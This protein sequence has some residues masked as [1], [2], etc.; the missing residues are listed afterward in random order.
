MP[1]QWTSLTIDA[2][3]VDAWA[4]HYPPH[5]TGLRT[6]HL[7]GLDIDILDPDLAHEIHRRA[8]DRF[9]AT[10]MRVGRWP[11]R[12]LPYRTLTPFRKIKVPGIE[13]LGA[14]QQFVAFGIHPVTGQPYSWPLGDTPLDVPLDALPVVDEDGLRA[15]LG[16]IG[17]ILPQEASG[18]RARR[19]PGVRSPS[20]GPVRDT[21]GRVLDGRDGWLSAIAFHAVHDAAERGAPR[22]AEALTAEVWARFAATADLDR[23][24]QGTGR[25]FALADARAKVADKLR[26]LHD[27]RLPGRSSDVPVP[28]DAPATLPVPEARAALDAGLAEACGEIEAWQATRSAP[29]PRIGFRASVGLGKSGLSRRHVMALRR[30]LAQQGLP[31]RILVFVPSHALA[32]EAAAAWRQAGAEVAVLRGY[33]ARD[34][35]TGQP[36]CRETGAVQTAIDA[37]LEVQKAVCDDGEG[38]RCRH[39][40]TCA[41]QRNRREVAAADIVVASHA[42]LFSGFAVEAS[43]IGVLLID[44]GFHGQV[45]EIT[46][47][48][49]VEGLAGMALAGLGRQAL[50]HRAAAATADLAALRQKAVRAL[51]ANGP[52]S[53]RKSALLAEGLTGEACGAALRLEAR[54]RELLH[55]HPGM[56]AADQQAAAGIVARNVAVDRLTAL[57]K[58]LRDL[59]SGLPESDGRVRI[60]D[61]DPVTGL[62]GIAVIGCREFHPNF[63]SLPVLHL[64]ATLRPE[65]AGAL[66]PGLEVREIEAA[67]PHM[68]L[69]LVAGRFGKT[70][71]CQDAR[72]SADENARRARKRADCVDYVRWHA[73]RVAPGRTL[74]VTYKD[75]EAAFE[76]IPGVEV[77]HFNAIAGLDAWRDV[78]LLIVIGRV[79][80]RDS[81]L[82]A[83]VA[84]LFGHAIEGGYS[85]ATKGIRMRDGSARAVRV[86]RHADDK[87]EI[88]RAAICDDEMIQAIGRGRGVNR[89]A[90][91]PLEVHVLADVALPLVHDRVTS[92]ELEAPDLFQRMLLAGIAV[93]SPADAAALHPQLLANRKQAQMAF[94]R[95]GFG[96]HFH[97]RDPYREMLPKSARY[98][99]P[100]RGRGWQTAWWLEGDADAAQAALEGVLGPLAGW[101]PGVLDD[102]GRRA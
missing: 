45:V 100:G 5:G 55:L 31:D 32:E 24:R 96:Q 57:W 48:L 37:R 93:D 101:E 77:A 39:F 61:P 25:P 9:G 69:T 99:R 34:P 67:T 42:A 66:L 12:L 59:A 14:G 3:Q 51:A 1:A 75:C 49:T 56:T 70:R 82:R 92:W 85:H 26:L 7:V 8:V 53:L 60:G 98:R 72:A 18:S 4:T 86:L 33:S 71:L 65:M 74:V 15:F 83:P 47:G 20:L 2:A 73:R 27:G 88:L 68:A 95:A 28:D 79:L 10:L 84:A 89:D 44:E 97:L 36:L 30:R 19:E 22:D 78:A 40:E 81:D 29:P 54:R 58:A 80:P 87:A 46:S 63:R 11:K 13:V 91:T 90:A 94:A 35:L 6:G 21:A 52:G 76:G 43:R 50:H 16:E 102:E 62:H 23:P 41:K 38:R 64:D 17:A